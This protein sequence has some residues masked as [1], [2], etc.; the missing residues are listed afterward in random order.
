MFDPAFEVGALLMVILM[1]LDTALH[2]PAGLLVVK[3]KVTVPVLLPLGENTIE[4]GLAV[5]D[6]ELS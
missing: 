3:V 2:G 4:D 5:G 6:V 1:L